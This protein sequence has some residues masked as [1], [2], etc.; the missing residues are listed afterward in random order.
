MTTQQPKRGL[1]DFFKPYVRARFSPAP[2]IPQKRP[3]PLPEGPS[4]LAMSQLDGPAFSKSSTPKR[5][6]STPPVPQRQDA[7]GRMTPD[8]PSQVS[9]IT[10]HSTRLAIRTPKSVRS[11][12]LP[13]TEEPEDATPSLVSRRFDSVSD[14]S[15]PPSSPTSPSPAK[16]VK[17]SAVDRSTVP[18]GTQSVVRGGKVVAVR[19]SDEEDTDSIGSLTDLF[20]VN[21]HD[22]GPTEETDRDRLE[23]DRVST[24]KLFLNG[25]PDPAASKHRLREIMAMK[26]S[27]K[28]SAAKFLDYQRSDAADA[29]ALEKLKHRY[30][31]TLRD[32][33]AAA[34]SAMSKADM[35]TNLEASVGDDDG[36]E[37]IIGAVRR[38]EALSVDASYTFFGSAGMRDLSR[39]RPKLP[40][41][42]SDAIPFEL[43]R[44]YDDDSRARVYQTGI[45]TH[46]AT[47]K[48]LDDSALDW[49]FEAFTSEADLSQRS[50]YAECLEAAAPVWARYHVNPEDVQFC[51]WSLSAKQENMAHSSRYELRPQ[52]LQAP[53]LHTE[54][55]VS[56]LDLFIKICA[57]MS[58]E[59]L[60]A[61]TTILCQ[62]SADASLMAISSVAS[63]VE[64]LFEY[65]LGRYSD[66][67]NALF[68]ASHMVL[69]LPQTLH[70]PTLQARLLE[71][72]RPT[73]ECAINTRIT[74]ANLF[75]FGVSSP[76]TSSIASR[77]PGVYLPA[78]TRLILTSD[79]FATARLRTTL[80]Y[81]DL[82]ARTIIL[83]IAI[84]DGGR[85]ASFPSGT[86]Q[87]AS[88]FNREIDALATAVR[89]TWRN[90]ADTGASHMKRTEA[91]E[92]LDC[93]YHRLVY[94][95]RT[96][97][98]QKRHVFDPTTGK[99]GD[100]DEV[101]EKERG[102]VAMKKFLEIT[103]QN[104]KDGPRS[105]H[106]AIKVERTLMAE[107][108]DAC[109]ESMDV[110]M[111]DRAP[112]TVPIGV[113]VRTDLLHTATARSDAR[114]ASSS[115]T[116]YADALEYQTSPPAAI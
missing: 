71:H 102:R 17:L 80:N 9:A 115:A 48:Q 47:R 32:L 51:F 114:R 68:I 74:L 94:V 31:S 110:G 106:V 90:I 13:T 15:S 3:S 75:L 81:T 103:K 84:S 63:R 52:P 2:T 83:D 92:K 62:I 87:K 58:F 10:P 7:A 18:P 113:T 70:E 64:D 22:E 42:P 44:H 50:A 109:E 97:P 16:Q 60:S 8:P 98:P 100:G 54:Y 38:T 116:A 86:Y 69:T 37:H 76:Q 40:A 85:P 35:L 33:D 66:E 107:D 20:G 23:A 56:T 111:D 25:A 29:Q 59:S 39:D 91:K 53:A 14:L 30:D 89:K 4:S 1:A 108:R 99:L 11:G 28:R 95:V 93:V 88:D 26:K 43:W 82:R 73:S 46:L 27:T 41:F 72:I 6:P 49:T 12:A 5:R 96:E 55:M 61:L 45:M 104:G 24:L 67:E 112:E 101:R 36:A 65:L 77:P 34:S 105:G 21:E 57:H 19:D 78:L 79:D